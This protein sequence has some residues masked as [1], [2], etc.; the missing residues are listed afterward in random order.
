M[1]T[2]ETFKKPWMKTV[3]LWAALYNIVFG[4]CTVLFPN[5]LFN[6]AGMEPLNYPGVWQCVGM[7]VGVYGIGYG[8]AAFAPLTHWPI[9]LVGLLGKIFGPIGFIYAL[10]IG[11]FNVQFGS[12][13]ITN[14]LIWWLPFFFILKAAYSDWHKTQPKAVPFKQALEHVLVDESTTLGE[15]SN[16]SPVLLVF[17]RHSGCTFC[18]ETLAQL[19]AFV[20]RE[21]TSLRPV[22]VTMSSDQSNQALKATY[23]LDTVPFISDPKRELYAA[24][25]LR[26]GRLLQLFGLK[27]WVR[28]VQAAFQGHGI[29]ALD[30]DGFQMPGTFIIKNGEIVKGYRQDSAGDF[31]VP[32]NNASEFCSINM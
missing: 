19:S 11:E 32:E 6:F 18:K 4:A 22:V 13:I 15:Y 26:R 2:K 23:E 28:G 31:W 8:I 29:G 9:V 14:D 17:L 27:V 1:T 21:K 7:I 12:I 3:L 16:Q 10:L 30:G 24:F 5:A 25:E 20:Q